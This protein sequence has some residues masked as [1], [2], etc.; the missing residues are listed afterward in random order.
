[1]KT[2]YI[3]CNM[4][5]AGDMLL[6]SLAELTGDVKA[7]EEKLNSLGI[8]DVTYNFE[9]SV[10]CGIEGTHARVV[11]LGVEEDEHMHEHEHH[12][13]DHEE[14]EHSHEHEHE[15]EHDHEHTHEEHTHDHHHHHTHMSDIVNI[16]SGLNVSDKV[17]QNALAV[18]GLIAEAESRAH[19]KPVSEIHFHEV[20]TLDAV[21]DIVGV[22]VLLKQLA[23]DR[24][25]VSPLA[26]GFGQVKCAHGILPVPAPATA[27]II[28]GIPSY[29]GSV[30]GELLTPT[31]AALLKY[32]ADSFGQRPV[33]AVSGTG[34]GMGKKD[35]PKAN[36]LRTFLGDSEG[37]G[38]KVI[39][40]RFNV[41]DMTGEETGY[42][43]GVLMENGALD[44]FTTPV[45]MKKNRPGILFTVLVKPEDKER[46]AKLIF[47]NTTTIG[48]RYNEM[49]RFRLD[50]REEKV[51]T[52][53]GEISV[54]VTE[55]FGVTK[56]KPEYDDIKNAI[57]NG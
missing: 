31:G 47:E 25:I 22:C 41:D 5:A 6:A 36:M 20:G 37:E 33:M 26:T 3:E 29:S 43:T 10:K 55:G 28:E 32:F 39:E 40:L 2:L 16:I 9:K 27:S 48:I 24:I 1:M 19:G 13:H 57:H 14:H 12:Y 15:H 4:G 34:C 35:F 53:Y 54:K 18:Y 45:F 52:K 17:K 49:D 30:E 23:P 56:A 21:A 51:M 38:D 42:A 50:R 44:V 11:V 7:C 8:P 46:F